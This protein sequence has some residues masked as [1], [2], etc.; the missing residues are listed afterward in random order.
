MTSH[1]SAYL[2]ELKYSLVKKIRGYTT[3]PDSGTASSMPVTV[4][5]I[6]TNLR[7]R[8]LESRLEALWYLCA[9][10]RGFWPAM[11]LGIGTLQR[12]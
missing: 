2:L 8:S 1:S 9:Y 7:Q 10:A 5:V 3:L 6:T 11:Y 12:E 4:G